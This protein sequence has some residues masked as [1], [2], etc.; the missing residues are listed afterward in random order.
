VPPVLG[1]LRYLNDPDCATKEHPSGEGGCTCAIHLGE[2][3]HQEF[4]PP[5]DATGDQ[6]RKAWD[7]ARKGDKRADPAVLSHND[8]VA[9]ANGSRPGG[10]YD[11][12][13]WGLSVSTHR[14]GI[15]NT[16]IFYSC[17]YGVWMCL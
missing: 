6:A 8:I 10:V 2:L 17:V 11:P 5:S 12:V 7:T 9:R 16:F 1:K 3:A 13:S 14:I 4:K 15:N